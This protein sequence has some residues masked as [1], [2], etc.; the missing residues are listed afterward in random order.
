MDLPLRRLFLSRFLRGELGRAVTML[1]IS[2]AD[3][4]LRRLLLA[5]LLRGHSRRWAV[6][7]L[8]SAACSRYRRFSRRESELVYQAV[9]SPGARFGLATSDPLPRRL[10]TRKLRRALHEA[11]QTD[12]L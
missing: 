2:G 3:A 9:L 12:L 4:R 8:L 11:H 1:T 7:I 5:R 10:Q 6:Y